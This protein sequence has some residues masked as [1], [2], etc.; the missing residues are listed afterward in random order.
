MNEY[1]IRDGQVSYSSVSKYHECPRA[2][3]YRYNQKLKRIH[4]PDGADPLLLG[5]TVHIGMQYDIKTASDFYFSQFCILDDLQINEMIKIEYWIKRGQEYLLELDIIHREYEISTEDY[6]GTI[7]LIVD[8]HD[9]TVDIIDYKYCSANSVPRYVMSEQ[10]HLYKY[11]LEST[12]DFKVKNLKFVIFPKLFIRQ[13]DNE[14]LAAFRN[15]IKSDLSTMNYEILRIDFLPEMLSMFAKKIKLL[16]SDTEFLPNRGEQCSRCVYERICNGRD[17][18]NMLPDNK[19]VDIGIEGVKVLWLY[20]PSFV[21]KTTGVDGYDGNEGFPSPLNFNT[22]GNTQ[23]VSMPRLKIENKVKMIGRLREETLA[24]IIFKEALYELKTNSAGFKTLVLDLTEDFF[25]FCRLYIYD[26]DKIEHESD[27]SFKYYDLVR[28]E[29]L[30]TIRDIKSISSLEWLIFVSHE[31]TSKDIMKSSGN[32]V[33]AIKPN[34]TDKVAKKLAGMSSAVA[35]VMVKPDGTRILSFKTD[36]V[37]FGGGRLDIKNVEIPWTY[38]EVKALFDGAV[39]KKKTSTSAKKETIRDQRLDDGEG[40]EVVKEDE[41][42]KVFNEEDVKDTTRK[43]RIKKDDVTK[44]EEPK[45]TGRKSRAAA[46]EQDE[47]YYPEPTINGVP[48]SQVPYDEAPEEELP[49][50]E[51]KVEAPKEETEKP[52]PERKRRSRN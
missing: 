3:D 12:T 8:N 18:Y 42:D 19:A 15:R 25:E 27:N 37:I 48:I 23:M 13:K 33:T 30:S 51:P 17:D 50:A 9:G 34:I 38:L 20:G 41:A 43:S 5:S 10:L 45:S 35:R 47:E 2:Y 31:D 44:D 16:K 52:K 46:K 14:T 7:D 40:I 21:G 11:F 24:W 4:A 36:E 32:N 39:H 22:D 49:K 28:T 6:R 29:F 1:V 26:R